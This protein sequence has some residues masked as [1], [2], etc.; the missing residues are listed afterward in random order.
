[1]K[2]YRISKYNPKDYKNGRYIK[3]E[4][5]EFSDIGCYFNGVK[6]TYE[7]YLEVEER[8]IS[9]MMEI[10]KLSDWRKIRL[11]N[12]ENYEDKVSWENNQILTLQE[13]SQVLRDCL[14]NECWCSLSYG[15]KYIM[16]SSD[17]YFRIGTTCSDKT[18][19]KLSDRYLL[20]C[21]RESVCHP[22][23]KNLK[24]YK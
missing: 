22:L 17:Y 8:Y 2:Y 20:H 11:K 5:T 21:K 10:I 14:R 3:D 7:D 9:F 24:Y 16:V 15:K 13:A 12:L 6:F 19:R 18:V 1:M 23:M 4:W